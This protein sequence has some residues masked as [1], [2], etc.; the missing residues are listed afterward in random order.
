MSA[1]IDSILPG[2]VT[3]RLWSQQLVDKPSDRYTVSQQGAPVQGGAG[4]RHWFL[5]YFLWGAAGRHATVFG[6]LLL[7][8]CESWALNSGCQAW[9]QAPFPTEPSRQLTRHY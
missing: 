6:A 5:S 3:A 7:L 4:H 9:E 2:K 1:S 8:L